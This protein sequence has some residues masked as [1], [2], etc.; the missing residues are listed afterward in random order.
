MATVY[1]DLPNVTNG[2][3]T[4]AS[5]KNQTGWNAYSPAA[6]D[7]LL[8]KRGTT[9]AANAFTLTAGTA[10]NLIKWGAWYNAD[11]TD[12]STKALPVITTTTVLS[13][14]ISTNKD[15][16]WLDKIK[17]V[18]SGITVAND[19][20]LVFMGT[21][22]KIT[23]C[24]FDAN[25]GCVYASGKASLTITGN[26]FYGVSHSSANN[27]N[28][29]TIDGAATLDSITFSRNNIYHYGG[30]SST[31]CGFKIANTSPSNFTNFL[32][33]HNVVTTSTGAANANLGAI[34]ARFSRC[35]S[36]LI[37]D[38]TITYFQDG[39]FITDMTATIG[40]NT[41]TNNY[42]FGLHLSTDAINCTIERNVCSYNGTSINNGVTLFAYGR[43]IEL[44]G[45]AGQ[46]RC[47]GHTI[48]FNTC[49]YNYNYGGPNDNGSE[50]C[51]IGL[52]DAT[53]NCTVYGNTCRFNEGNGIQ[54]Y[55]GTIGSG[56][57][58]IT[59][60]GNHK[61]IANFVSSNCTAAY[62][63][64]QTGGTFTNN[65]NADISLSNIVGT[66]SYIA[67]N[68]CNS[69]CPAA[70]NINS[71]CDGKLIIANNIITNTYGIG[72]D[73]AYSISTGGI[74]SNDFTGATRKYFTRTTDANGS[75]TFTVNAYVATNDLTVD[76]KWD[77]SY[78]LSAG[79]TL[80]S[81][82]FALGG[83]RLDFGGRVFNANPSIGM[84]EWFVNVPPAQSNL[85][86]RL[87]RTVFHRR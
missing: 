69:N 48:R 60:T 68:V 52:D 15:Y 36:A 23:D 3:G 9:S 24:Y 4:S 81:A 66:T 57:P 78:F 39:I 28:V 79:S 61:I 80:I 76:P 26:T 33:Q 1:F 34:G 51:G 41:L 63:S 62:T 2:T 84:Y 13:T 18:A 59:D 29:V 83:T 72:M 75:C 31:S 71:G 32:F 40:S 85:G 82:G 38:N 46:S 22:A 87:R 64:R 19:K 86:G 11:G 54:C 14:S 16:T 58:A 49:E 70:I 67:N 8:F 10:G 30:G 37:T 20:V 44:S 50:G 5:P 6:G 42:H 17:L 25:I 53:N 74:T 45:A 73:S 35:S 43:G 27:N 65:F 77:N 47:T 55:G 56:S 7:I 21:G 12:D